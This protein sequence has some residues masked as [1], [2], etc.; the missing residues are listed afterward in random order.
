MSPLRVRSAPAALAAAF[1][2]GLAPAGWEVAAEEAAA[3]A[4][5][6]AE[7]AMSPGRAFAQTGGE[8]LYAGVC[9][10]CHQARGEG[11]VGAATYLSLAHDERLEAAGYPVTVVL[12]GLRGM[13][14][15]GR[16]LS[17]AQVADVVNYVRT[18]FDNHY[19]DAVSAE[20]VK[21]ARP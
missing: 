11:A 20:D 3:P 1:L 4:A 18:H 9:A 19:A 2:L 12:H 6:S 7:P 17:D 14:A 10:A 21:A 15:L 16:M 5:P 8:A 13:P